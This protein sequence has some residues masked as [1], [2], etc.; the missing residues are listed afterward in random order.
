MQPTLGRIVLYK[1]YGGFG[2]G[3]PYPAIVNG[4]RTNGVIDLW[5]FA[6]NSPY[7]AHPLSM[8]NSAS[9][10]QPGQWWLPERV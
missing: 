10:A 2:D 8:A 3:R 1:P 6:G 7:Q 5:V 4:I 9:E